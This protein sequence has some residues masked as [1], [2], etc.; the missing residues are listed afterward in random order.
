MSQL[1]LLLKIV[2]SRMKA[3]EFFLLLKNKKPVIRQGY[4]D[5]EANVILA[6]CNEM[7]LNMIK[8]DFAIELAESGFANKG[9]KSKE[10]MCFYYISKDPNLAVAAKEA[11][12]T[13][14]HKTLGKFL[15]YPPCCIDFFETNFSQTH[16]NLQLTPARW[17]TNL[18]K[19]VSDWCVLSHFPCS[20][21]CK[22]SLSLTTTYF[23]IILEDNPHWAKELK[24]NL[25]SNISNE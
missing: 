6:L 16:T 10:G 21:D 13:D 17:E 14:D 22:H 11:E 25:E 18:T 1:S 8:S 4:Y 20:N 23:R 2:G 3:Q 7:R 12:S 19:R 15:D 5:D 24:T 9:V